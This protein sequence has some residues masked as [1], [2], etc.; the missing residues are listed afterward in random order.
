MPLQARSEKTMP[1]TT[2]LRRKKWVSKG[3]SIED[4]EDLAKEAMTGIGPYAW[5][6]ETNLELEENEINQAEEIDSQTDFSYGIEQSIIDTQRRRVVINTVDVC[7][8]LIDLYGSVYA[9]VLLVHLNKFL[10]KLAKACEQPTSEPIILNK[11]EKQLLIAIMLSSGT[12]NEWDRSTLERL[13]V[14]LHLIS[15]ALWLWGR[16]I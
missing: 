8:I 7:R 2:Y 1:K 12:K 5:E 4:D 14:I 16:N 11:K 15:L 6:V 3:Y 10:E 13:G 9:L